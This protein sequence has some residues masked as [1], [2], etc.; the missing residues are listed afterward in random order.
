MQ[1]VRVAGLGTFG[2]VREQFHGK[3]EL[4]L[5]QRPFFQLDIDELWLEE[6]YCP[7][8]I[9]PGE[10]AAAPLFLPHVRNGL[11]S[12]LFGKAWEK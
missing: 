8:E 6:I 9:L 7:T 4:L 5:I 3:E 11:F 10:K 1:G 2:V 12:L